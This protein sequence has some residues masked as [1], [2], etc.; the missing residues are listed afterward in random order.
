MKL[1]SVF[2]FKAPPKDELFDSVRFRESKVRPFGD[3]RRGR[4]LL[5]AEVPG[6]P[7]VGAERERVH[8]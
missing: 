8:L 5:R 7:Q 3:P 1:K 6:V 2:R 4:I